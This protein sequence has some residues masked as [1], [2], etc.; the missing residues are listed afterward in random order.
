MS[1]SKQQ[2]MESQLGLTGGF[3]SQNPSAKLINN[4]WSNYNDE[5][6]KILVHFKIS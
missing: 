4:P 6:E 2:S 5:G 3:K 1:D